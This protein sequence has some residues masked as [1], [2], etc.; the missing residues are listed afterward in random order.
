MSVSLARQRN[1]HGKF[2][3]MASNQLSTH[4]RGSSKRDGN[5][6]MRRR[7]KTSTYSHNTERK[8]PKRIVTLNPLKMVKQDLSDLY[9]AKKHKRLSTDW[10]AQE[11]KLFS[12][13]SSVKGMR[14]YV[15]SN[16][17][18]SRRSTSNKGSI[19]SLKASI[20]N[21]RHDSHAS[22][23]N[24]RQRSRESSNLPKLSLTGQVNPSKKESSHGQSKTTKNQTGVGQS[25][26]K[27]DNGETVEYDSVIL[28]NRVIKHSR[29]IDYEKGKPLALTDL[30]MMKFPKSSTHKRLNRNRMQQ[31]S[32]MQQRTGSSMSL[33]ER[34]N[35]K[36]R[37]VKK[38]QSKANK[39][40]IQEGVVD[41]AK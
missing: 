9:K 3:T 23:S 37:P 13:H 5:S 4:S 1:D 21:K 7:R 18:V 38:N 2:Q 31:N 6:E 41:E 22:R 19:N 8:G 17:Q 33:S 20:Q 27:K 32:K 29:K 36:F 28:R 12:F 25:G 35:Q 40:H 14:N 10:N 26:F 16:S 24:S 30:T 11:V 15:R 34:K 39:M